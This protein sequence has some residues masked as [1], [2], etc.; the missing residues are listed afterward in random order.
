MRNVTFRNN[1]GTGI[2]LNGISANLTNVNFN[3]NTA[4]YGVGMSIRS[5]EVYFQ[6]V[7]FMKNT[8]F[9]GGVI[10]ILSGFSCT[11]FDFENN[12]DST[13]IIFSENDINSNI[14]LDDPE[15]VKELHLD[16]YTIE[17]NLNYLT[18]GPTSLKLNHN[19]LLDHV[20][21]GQELVFPVTVVDS[22]GHNGTSCISIPELEC[23]L[24]Q[25][26][27]IGNTTLKLNTKR[28]QI[29]QTNER[30]ESGLHLTATHEFIEQSTTFKIKFTC[31][32]T[33]RY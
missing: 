26:C 8:G 23:E 29:L 2:S 33:H 9:F 21:P 6:N 22:L 12:N 5:S 18:T 17:N 32:K 28:Q 14:Y 31:A 10:H 13:S 30:Y 1:F 16:N 19:N 27:I 7:S 15:C 25:P 4:L 3:N 24:N 20:F 11:E